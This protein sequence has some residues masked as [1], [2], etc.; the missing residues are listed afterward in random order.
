MK[1]ATRKQFNILL[2]RF[3]KGYGVAN[4]SEQFAIDP[5]IAQDFRDKIVELSTFLQKINVLPVDELKGQKIFGFA[6]RPVTGR[7]D[8]TVAGQEREPINIVGMTDDIY[9]LFQTNADV[10]MPYH[11]IDAW[12]KFKDFADRY[13]KYVRQ[14]MANDKEIIGWHGISAAAT[15]NFATNPLLEDVN[16]GW[17][18]LM[19]EKKPDNIVTEGATPGKVRIGAGGDYINLDIA[20]NDLAHG[21]P[22]YKRAGLVALV[23]SDLIARERTALF[24][25]VDGKPTEKLAYNQAMA[26]LGGLPWETPSNFPARGLVVTSYDNLSIYQQEDSHRRKI[27]DNARKNQVEDFNSVNEGYVVE[28][29]EKF[30]G[31]EFKNVELPDGAG[32][33]E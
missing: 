24:A 2:E 14:R 20:V 11:L 19:R 33:W 1:T 13:A 7:T 3:A 15:T 27:E 31:L 30:V 8:T 9:E 18:Q 6:S 29:Y 4:V 21:I 28:D 16:K 26:T 22:E 25:A 5:S 12:A 32:G 23:G 10:A 17:M